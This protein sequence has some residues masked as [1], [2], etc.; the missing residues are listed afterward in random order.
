MNEKSYY[1]QVDLER[2][3]LDSEGNKIISKIKYSL[4]PDYSNML[5]SLGMIEE[6]YHDSVYSDVSSHISERFAGSGFLPNKLVSPQALEN[7]DENE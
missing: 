4:P 1:W 2:W 5:D 7:Y 6:V 3:L